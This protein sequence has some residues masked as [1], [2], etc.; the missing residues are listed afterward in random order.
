[1]ETSLELAISRTPNA[2]FGFMLLIIELP[3]GD[4]LSDL[5]IAVLDLDAL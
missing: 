3:K 1:L 5:G 2:E 4:Q